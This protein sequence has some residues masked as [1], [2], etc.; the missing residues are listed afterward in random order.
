MPILGMCD[1]IDFPSDPIPRKTI[2]M[3]IYQYGANTVYESLP[4]Q[5]TGNRNWAISNYSYEMTIKLLILISLIRKK[6]SL[7][8]RKHCQ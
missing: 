5:G 4:R 3:V 1:T 7:W 2:T 8:L 6:K